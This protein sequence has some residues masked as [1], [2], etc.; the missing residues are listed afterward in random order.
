MSTKKAL[1]AEQNTRFEK[2]MDPNGEQIT[3]KKLNAVDPSL[4]LFMA[5]FYQKH[6]DLMKKLEDK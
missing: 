3:F 1:N 2:I 6:S 4:N 5:N